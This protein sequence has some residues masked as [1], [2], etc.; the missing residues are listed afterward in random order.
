MGQAA[1]S[2]APDWPAPNFGP[3]LDA[4]A[5]W[6]EQRGI[7]ELSEEEATELAVAEVR[8]H[9]AERAAAYKPR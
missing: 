5:K 4:A 3:I 9:R 6:R 1:E 8:A 2:E 7:P